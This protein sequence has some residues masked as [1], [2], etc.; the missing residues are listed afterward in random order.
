[1]LFLIRKEF[2]YLRPFILSFRRDPDNIWV[3]YVHRTLVEDREEDFIVWGFHLNR[4][5]LMQRK[6]YEEWTN[7][8]MHAQPYDLEY[9][10]SVVRTI[11]S[12]A[13][14]GTPRDGIEIALRQ[15]HRRYGT[16]NRNGYLIN[17]TGTSLANRAD[18]TESHV[19]VPA[20]RLFH[21]FI[22]FKD[23][24]FM[25]MPMTL[26]SDPQCF[27]DSEEETLHTRHSTHLY[28]MY[29]NP[30]IREVIWRPLLR[31][32]AETQ[33]VKADQDVE[34][35]LDLIKEFDNTLIRDKSPVVYLEAINGYLPKT[36]VIPKNGSVAFKY[37]ALGLE[38]G[39]EMR[40]KAGFHRQPGMAELTFK[41]V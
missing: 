33:E 2:S 17:L 25:Q 23:D 16:I 6:D 7:Y 36:R 28:Q 9:M 3:R 14:N 21:F 35:R 4:Q 27:I 15:K 12:F 31:L 19:Y 38:P 8:A 41:V 20:Y 24:D 22:K 13:A 34:V 30:K 32:S 37:R 40:V 1:M 39:D 18:S 10:N 26:I 5:A 29:D 11:D